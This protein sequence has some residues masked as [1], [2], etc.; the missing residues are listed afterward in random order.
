MNTA[1]PALVKSG[2][3]ESVHPGAKR[4][5]H[6]AP[7]LLK[8]GQGWRVVPSGDLSERARSE[9]VAQSGLARPERFEL[10]TPRSVVWCS[11]QLSYGRFGRS[12]Q[13]PKF[14]RRTLHNA[15]SDSKDGRWRLILSQ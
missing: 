11:I 13:R 5:W 9:D 7:C 14:R 6:L 10:P 12:S 4:L 2:A 3:I 1:I 8:S 15:G